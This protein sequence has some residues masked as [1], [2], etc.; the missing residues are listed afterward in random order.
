MLGSRREPDYAP[1][2]MGS[3]KRGILG[4]VKLTEHIL[5][6]ELRKEAK[7]EIH[8]FCGTLER[9]YDIGEAK[10]FNVR[11]CSSLENDTETGEHRRGKVAHSERTVP[12]Y[13]LEEHSSL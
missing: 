4:K 2:L 12:S 7:F 8:D 13:L 1:D 6:E 9:R 3:E 10:D 5:I 11:S